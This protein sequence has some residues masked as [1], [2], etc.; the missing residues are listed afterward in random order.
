[1]DKADQ[2]TVL[3]AASSLSMTKSHAFFS[4][5]P[6]P[7]DLTYNSV[8][9]ISPADALNGQ[10]NNDPQNPD[11][12]ILESLL[13]IA[14]TFPGTGR[15]E[16]ASSDASDGVTGS[17]LRRK[18][19]LYF[20][21]DQRGDNSLEDLIQKHSNPFPSSLKDNDA[22]DRVKAPNRTLL[23]VPEENIKH[24]ADSLVPGVSDFRYSQNP[25]PRK[26]QDEVLN[27]QKDIGESQERN[28]VNDEKVS[29]FKENSGFFKDKSALSPLT[30]NKDLSNDRIRRAEEMT[31]MSYS[32]SNIVSI[33]G[34]RD[35]TLLA[36]RKNLNLQFYTKNRNRLKPSTSFLS[37]VFQPV[38]KLAQPLIRAITGHGDE[39]HNKGGKF[40]VEDQIELPAITNFFKEYSRNKSS[41]STDL[42]REKRATET[43]V[44]TESDLDAIYDYVLLICLAVHQYA[45]VHGSVP[46]AGTLLDTITNVTFQGHQGE[47]SVGPDH[48]VAYD[49]QV[50]DFDVAQGVMESKLTY[51][52]AG[53]NE[54]TLSDSM[55]IAWPGGVVPPEDECFKQL[56]GCND[57]LGTAYIIVVV[58][59]VSGVITLVTIGAYFAR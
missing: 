2:L 23:Y 57:G 3:L 4:F 14:P 7:Y 29:N 32:S 17:S 59:A 11:L 38:G 25:R 39:K 24:R 50:Y 16:N 55:D 34:K 53:E 10:F 19:D 18:R 20:T 43:F 46:L 36:N 6:S 54:W 28:K 44:A 27:F 42:R 51:S 33:A 58:I 1:M 26:I 35:S 21:M 41:S 31:T 30:E 5:A 56:P 9:G 8:L 12:N 13:V 49:F 37:S 15:G 52:V 40:D 22:S 45:A 48:E 47:I